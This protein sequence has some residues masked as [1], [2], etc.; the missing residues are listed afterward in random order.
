MISVWGS[1]WDEISKTLSEY[2]SLMN[3][4]DKK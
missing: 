4:I 3:K 2:V 1:E